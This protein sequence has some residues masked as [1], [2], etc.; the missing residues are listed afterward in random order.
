MALTVLLGGARSGKSAL[1]VEM[2]SRFDSTAA[3]TPDD[4]AGGVV[5]VATARTTD[6]P[7]MAE[8]VDRHR[9]QRPSHWMTVEAPE[10]LGPALADVPAGCLAI[11]DCL[12]LWTSNRMEV[13]D[14]D[15]T[16]EAAARSTA[17]QAAARPGPTIAVSNLVGLGVHPATELGRRFRDVH[18]RVNQIWAAAARDA[19]LVIAG[20]TLPLGGPLDLLASWSADELD[21]DPPTS[22]TG[23]G[24]ESASEDGPG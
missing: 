1:A 16:I 5:F 14:E 3:T 12:T 4:A 6:D 21:A 2:A 24:D 15:V 19:W 7:D 20:R 17:S 9:S 10:E 13:G 11:V 18:G 23:A 22:T 8:R